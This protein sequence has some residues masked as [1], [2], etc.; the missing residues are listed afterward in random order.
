VDEIVAIDQVE[1]RPR[2]GSGRPGSTSRASVLVLVIRGDLLAKYPKPVVYAQQAMWARGATRPSLASLDPAGETR[3]PLLRATLDPDIMLVGFDLGEQGGARP[4][5]AIRAP[6]PTHQGWFF[7]LMERPGQPR[8]GLDDESPAGGLQTWNDLAWDA[9]AFPND[10][11]KR[12]NSLPTPRWRRPSPSR[13]SGGAPQ[14]TW[15]P[16]LFQ[17]PVLLARHASEM[18]PWTVDLANLVADAGGG[19]SGAPSTPCSSARGRAMDDGVPVVLLPVRL[20]TR[21][22]RVQVPVAVPDTLAD[23]AQALNRRSAR[24]ARSPRRTLAPRARTPSRCR[25]S[26]RPRSRTRCAISWPSASTTRAPPSDAAD[27]LVRQHL[28]GDPKPVVAVDRGRC[29][30]RFRAPEGP[31]PGCAPSGSSTGSRRS[32]TRSRPTPSERCGDRATRAAR[33]RAARRAGHATSPRAMSR[34]SSRRR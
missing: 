5:P 12:S 34:R 17:Q 10:T 13:P 25:S 32:S 33:S 30:V 29:A 27:L 26:S 19:K 22:V 24:S 11:P 16:I 4:P 9:L 8:F 1:G 18:L 15:R 20:E 3:Q 6:T 28:D 2:P 14:A 21:F 7:V 23:L 31:S